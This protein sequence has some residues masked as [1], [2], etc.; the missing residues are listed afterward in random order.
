MVY[1]IL[2]EKLKSLGRLHW[3]QQECETL[4]DADLYHTVPNQAYNRI[5]RGK[6]L[7]PEAQQRL[8]ALATWR[9]QTAQK[10]DKPR[11]WIVRD[12]ALCDIAISNPED[13]EALTN[14]KR[15]TTG[16]RRRW[17]QSLIDVLKFCPTDPST[18]IWKAR[19]SLSPSQESLTKQ[20]M[21]LIRQSAEQNKLAPSL[22]GTKRDV[23][24]LIWG[25]RM[26][27]LTKGWRRELVGE[28]ILSLLE[29][30]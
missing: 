1:Q 2:L 30:G 22:L 10:H 4:L 3:V 13:F 28:K 23:E 7:A 26:S 5:K 25:D 6:S 14:I 8:R 12:A 24:K 17:G 9:E 16:V 18:V 29:Q 15:L 27:P 19:Q 21:A 11:E 20:L